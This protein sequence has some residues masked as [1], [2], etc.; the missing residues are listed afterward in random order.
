[1]TNVRV[2]P[3]DQTGANVSQL[4]RVRTF[5][6][7]PVVAAFAGFICA[8]I[9][10]EADVF[11]G[12]TGFVFGASLI[13]C[14]WGLAHSSTIGLHPLYR[15][16][17]PGIGLLRLGVIGAVIWCAYVLFNHADP[18]IEGWWTLLYAAMAFAA[19]K[20]FGQFGAE[21]FG[22]RL[23]EDVFE[24][25]NWAAAQF[26]AAYTFSTG[27]IFGAAM[28]GEM[29]PDSLDYGWVFRWL[30]G[31]E[32]GWWITPW[33]FLL[34]W[35]ILTATMVFYFRR[36]QDNFRQR[37]VRERNAEDA[38]A[39]SLFCIA[40][41]ITIAYAVEGDYLGFFHSLAGFSLIALPILAHEIMRPARGHVKRQK[42]E[43]WLYILMALIGIAVAPWMAGLIGL[44]LF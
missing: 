22:P 4:S 20:L 10:Y 7:F 17:N 2:L 41:A 44:D 34:G 14:I 38:Q 35:G 43:G 6:A 36:E 9:F 25:K 31:Y 23:R 15:F 21:W 29:S 8:V 13:T 5:G 37:V 33:F 1:M 26:I 39:A 32:D 27:L 11:W 12:D 30:P 19:I 40:C 42:G 28:W 3:R 16:N 18:T 24:R